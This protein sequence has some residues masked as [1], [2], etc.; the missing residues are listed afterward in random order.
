MDLDN[1]T[2]KLDQDIFEHQKRNYENES[3]QVIKRAILDHLCTSDN[4]LFRIPGKKEDELTSQQKFEIANKLLSQSY[5]LFLAKFGNQLLQEH[6]CYFENASEEECVIVNI[7]LN[8][9]KN[10]FKLHESVAVPII[11]CIIITYGSLIF[12]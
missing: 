9:L 8:Q 3:R 10:V 5:G 12:K 11:V 6:L 7:Y 4:V 2:V 1:P